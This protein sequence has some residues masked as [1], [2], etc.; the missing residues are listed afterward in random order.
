MATTDIHPE[1]RNIARVIPRSPVRAATL[2]FIRAM[3]KLQQR[4]APRGVTPLI[5]SDGIGIRLHQGAAA[6]AP[7]PAML[8]I[9]GGGYVI[10]TAAQ[11]D[12]L[13]QKFASTLGITVAA[14]EYDLAPENPYPIA[15][16]QCYGALRWLSGLPAVDPDKLVIAGASAGG[17]LAAQLAFMVRDRGEFQLAAQHLVYPMLDD[18]S[19]H[20]E[21]PGYRLWNRHSNRFGWRSYLG[22]ADPDEVAPARRQDLAGLAPAWIGVGTLD[23]F[24]DEDIAYA[25]RLTAAGV[26]CQV[27][28]VPGAFHGFDQIAAKSAV[29]KAFFDSQFASLRA[30][31]A[32]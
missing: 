9:H 21:D 26:P 4:S 19:V 11:D 28:I 17:G 16:E 25:E 2:P 29:S 18:R 5:T 23:L 32:R 15:L 8:W 14:V 30:A 10:G 7:A 12:V 20:A 22:T 6:A 31:F 3:S 1:L 24:H 13:C 27:E